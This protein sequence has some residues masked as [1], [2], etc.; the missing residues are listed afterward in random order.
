MES[1]LLLI[2][3]QYVGAKLMRVYLALGFS[4]L[5]FSAHAQAT[6]TWQQ[7]QTFLA[8]A[9]VMGS[10]TAPIATDGSNFNVQNSSTNAYSMY[11]VLVPAGWM[12]N[13]AI[14]SAAVVPSGST[15]INTN[16]YGAYMQCNSTPSGSGGQCVNVF[17][18]GVTMVDNSRMWGLNPTLNDGASNVPSARTGR[19]LVGAEFDFT[20]ANTTANGTMI[21]GISLVINNLSANQQSAA[22]QIGSIGNGGWG[23]GLN[24]SDGGTSECI[25]AGIS[26]KT[27]PSDSSRIIFGRRDAGNAAH[28]DNLY[29]RADGYLVWNATGINTPNMPTSAGT[30][31]QYVCMDSTGSMY[32]KASCP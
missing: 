24:C 19:V 28:Q 17:S 1:C 18:V 12:Y 30:G 14:R 2:T 5:S 7:F 4:L 11:S 27:G 31:G 21:S 25:Y 22:I 6:S 9:A 20:T 3:D 23:V 10:N 32:K 8:G 13:D 15:A 29:S 26:A 16:N